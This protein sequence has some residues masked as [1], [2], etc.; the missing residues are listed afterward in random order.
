MT[1]DGTNVWRSGIEDVCS[2][3]VRGC[4]SKMRAV[5]KKA[6][7]D[8]SLTIPQISLTY[9]KADLASGGTDDWNKREW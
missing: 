2:V 7:A 9:P 5:G 1:E 6:M 8:N 4:Y 3:V